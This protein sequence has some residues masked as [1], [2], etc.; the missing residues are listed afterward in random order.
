LTHAQ[1][2]KQ[3]LKILDSWMANRSRGKEKF[4]E[5]QGPPEFPH[6]LEE[7]LKRGAN[8]STVWWD[9][10]TCNNRVVETKK[11]TMISK[12]F[13]VPACS[14]TP[15]ANKQLKAPVPSTLKQELQTPPLWR[16]PQ[17]EK[18]YT[19]EEQEVLDKAR[20]I[21]E[22]KSKPASMASSSTEDPK[23]RNYSKRSTPPKSE[24]VMDISSEDEFETVFTTSQKPMTEPST[25][26][27]LSQMESLTLLLKERQ[28]KSSQK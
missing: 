1:K 28:A 27:I 23:A 19:A 22:K 7:N 13:A 3:G 9:C 5:L 2:V 8:Q 12:Y 25:E 20:E 4:P 14:G 10:K 17:K 16:K 21:L 6:T 18:D 15:G 26:E 11:S 24:G